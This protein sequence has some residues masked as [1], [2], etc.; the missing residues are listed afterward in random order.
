[1][2]TRV[3]ILFA[4]PA[5]RH[6]RL[7]RYVASMV[8]ELERVTF[9]DLYETYPDF[10]IDVAAERQRCAEHDV[11]VFQHP[12]MWFSCP[13]ILKEWFDRVLTFRPSV[14]AVDPPLNDKFW[15]SV[16]SCSAAESDFVSGGSMSGP[17]QDALEPF[18][19]IAAIHGM[20]YMQPFVTYDANSKTPMEIHR[21]AEQYR[22]L[23]ISVRDRGLDASQKTV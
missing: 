13:A 7:N 17:L 10:H 18:E 20:H 16:I 2:D 23:L 8:N 6:S 4:H 9:V 11:L 3:L 22:Q 15:L 12:L 21:H 14:C 5:L 19:R 1:M